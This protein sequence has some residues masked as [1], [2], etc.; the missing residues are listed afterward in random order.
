MNTYEILRKLGTAAVISALALGS[1][2]A[3]D[4]SAGATA[5]VITPLTIVEDV[6]MHF[7]DISGGGT[8]GTVV[9]ATDDS[10][11]VTGGAQVLASGAGAA[12]QFTVTGGTGLVYAISFSAGSLD[13]A[14]GGLPMVVNTFTTNGF[15]GTLTGG[16][17]TF[18]V[19]ATLQVGANQPPGAYSTAFGAGSSYTVTFNYN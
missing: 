11:T 4:Y 13:V 15:T 2:Q 8:A 12:G 6:V 17:E 10:R 5:N 1:T 19:G 14:G 18:A 16:N 3:A 9:L 7:G